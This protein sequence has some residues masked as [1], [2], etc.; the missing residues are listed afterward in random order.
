M[1]FREHGEHQPSM[2]Q[3]ILAGRATE[4]DHV[5]GAVV[6]EARAG[7]GGPVTAT[8]WRLVRVRER[9][10]LGVHDGA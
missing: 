2:L 6:R 8:L 1:A 3:D 10:Y 4:I 9:G 7:H 5:N